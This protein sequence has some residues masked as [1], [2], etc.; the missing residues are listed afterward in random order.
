MVVAGFERNVV[1]VLEKEYVLIRG[2]WIYFDSFV[3]KRGFIHNSNIK[4]LVD[5]RSISGSKLF[6]KAN[7][8]FFFKLSLNT[9]E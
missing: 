2:E 8:I 4:E 5:W 9:L 1:I 3:I 6:S 7:R